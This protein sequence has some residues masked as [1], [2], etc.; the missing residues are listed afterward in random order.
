MGQVYFV[1][2][3]DQDWNEAKHINFPIIPQSDFTEY[4]IDMTGIGGWAGNLKRL[5]VDPSTNVT[6]GS[7]RIDY[8]R[9]I[10]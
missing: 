5:R 10:E 1:T 3:S 8:I 9:I 2:Q 6:T 4:T 7:F